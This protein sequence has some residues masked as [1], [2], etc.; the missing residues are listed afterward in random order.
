MYFMIESFFL[1]GVEHPPEGLEAQVAF[2]NGIVGM[3]P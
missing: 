1:K 2:W 3:S